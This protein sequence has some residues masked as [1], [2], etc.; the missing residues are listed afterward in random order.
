MQP[1]VYPLHCVHRVDHT[2]LPEH[3]Q[4]PE[5]GLML[6]LMPIQSYT[7]LI[8]TQGGGA[9]PLPGRTARG[10]LRF[11]FSSA[12]YISISVT[13]NSGKSVSNCST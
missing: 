13:V 12:V 7:V 8:N 11:R 6:M 1:F 3:L 4:G 9:Q 10:S 2:K 5:I